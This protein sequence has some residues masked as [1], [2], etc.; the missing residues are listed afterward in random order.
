[1]REVLNG[2]TLRAVTSVLPATQR[3][4]TDFIP[5]CGKDYVER[6]QTIVGV[7]TLHLATPEQKASDF[8]LAAA[9]KLF[10]ERPEI[11][12][13]SIDALLF[14][15][16]TPDGLA[17]ITASR[18]QAALD[19]PVTTLTLDINQG[20]T[21]FVAGLLLAANLL[22][23]P[24]FRNVLIV[25]GDTLSHHLAESDPNTAMLFSDGGFAAIIGKGEDAPWI[26]ETLNEP[27]TAITLPY[28]GS[29]QMMSSDVFNFT[30]MRVAEQLQALPKPDLYLLGQTNAFVLRQLARACGC[31]EQQMPCRIAHRGN[32]SGASLP[33][34]L[35]DLAAEGLTGSP[36][37]TLAA[38]GV[39]L[40]AMAVHLTLHT[41]AICPLG[42]L[43]PTGDLV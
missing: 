36:T 23:N 2:C 27:S 40:T 1:M 31:D 19:L 37:V 42:H 7:E 33:T 32:T 17:P 22:Q 29:L 30:L 26:F 18:L 12:P 24:A 38:F 15:S 5:V 9:Q 21:G 41:N 6:F 16:Q 14:L 43:S 4:L 39:G 35:C 8:A 3:A 13:K 11:D 25:G 34:L 10:R 28:G 20:C